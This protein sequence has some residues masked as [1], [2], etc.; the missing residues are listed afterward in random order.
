MADARVQEL[1]RELRERYGVRLVECP[2]AEQLYALRVFSKDARE[3]RWGWL[4]PWLDKIVEHC[5][6]KSLCVSTETWTAIE[7]GP[8]TLLEGHEGGCA[9]PHVPPWCR[10]VT[11]GMQCLA[12]PPDAPAGSMVLACTKL[13]GHG[14]AMIPHTWEDPF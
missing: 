12:P 6:K 14:D 7:S 13:A 3:D 9:V 4:G 2:T 8:C 1:L 5:T 10:L 11:G